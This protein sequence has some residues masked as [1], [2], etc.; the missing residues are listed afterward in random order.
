MAQQPQYVYKIIP[1]ASVD[2]R[3][4]FNQPIAASDTI[5][6]TELDLKDGFVHMSTAKQVPGVLKRFFDD[7][8]SVAIL[9]MDYARLSSFKRV[10]WDQTSSGE[11]F[12]HLH[13]QIEGENIDSF[14]EI[15]RNQSWDDALQWL[16]DWL[17]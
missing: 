10:T 13:A 5:M 11:S 4:Y 1:S 9:R 7:V 17:V 14:K 3:F 15:E 6:M 12:P 2:S 8:P 16:G